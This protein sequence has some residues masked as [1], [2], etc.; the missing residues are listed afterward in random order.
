MDLK[1]SIIVLF[2]LPAVLFAQMPN[3]I[4]KRFK[5]AA[6]D[7]VFIVSEMKQS[8]HKYTV[9]RL[10]QYVYWNA[11]DSAAFELKKGDVCGPVL[12]NDTGYVIKT[13]EVDSDLMMHVGQIFVGPDRIGRDSAQAIAE[14]ILKKI[15]SGTSFEKLCPTTYATQE[16]ETQCDLGW[17]VRGVMVAEFEA[18]ILKHKKGDVF[19]VETHYGFHVVKV[20]DDTARRRTSVKYDLYYVLP[21]NY[22][23]K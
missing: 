17:F 10:S 23:G 1:K 2:L 13:V 7:S 6:N 16:E 11:L 20:L 4:M 21:P 8:Y 3:V 9:D 14:R 5:N 12:M 22:G 18:A 15:N 19:I